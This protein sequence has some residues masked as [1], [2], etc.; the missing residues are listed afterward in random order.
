MHQGGFRYH[1]VGTDRADRGDLK[2][3]GSNMKRRFERSEKVQGILKLQNGVK[4]CQ[5]RGSGSKH[6]KL[7]DWDDLLLRARSQAFSAYDCM[8]QSNIVA[9]YSLLEPDTYPVSDGNGGTETIV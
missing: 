8:I 3:D 5:A 1:I 9:S 7:N 6:F 2:K 4:M